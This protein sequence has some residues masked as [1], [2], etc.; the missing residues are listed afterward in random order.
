MQDKWYLDIGNAKDELIKSPRDRAIYRFLEMVPGILS[1]GTLLFVTIMSWLAP[2]F[3]AFFIIAFDIYWLLKTVFLSFHLRATYK[4]MRRYAKI[5][6]L[7]ELKNKFGNNSPQPFLNLREGEKNSPNPPFIKGGKAGGF[8]KEGV[9][10]QEIFHLV[11]LPFYKEPFEVIDETLGAILK[12]NYPKQNLIVVLGAEDRA[13]ENAKK[14]AERIKQKYGNYFFKFIITIHPVIFGEL[15][16]KGSNATWMAKQAKKEIIDFLGLPHENIIVSNLDIDTR[17]YPDYFAR[18]AFE[19]LSAKNPHRCSFQPIPV[20]NNNIWYSNAFSR[21]VATS[22]TF[23]H[24]MQ[25]ERPERLAT[26]S[27]H[28]MSW[29]ALIELDFWNTKNVSEDSR[30]F[31]KSL[32]FYDGAYQVV[33]LYYPVSMDAALAP[34]F[35]ETIIN[36]YRQQKRWGWGSENIP[37][38][39]FGFIKNKKIGWRD[40]IFWT[41]NHLEGFW[42][43]GTNA[44]ILFMLGWLPLFLGGPQFNLTVLSYNLPQVTRVIMTLAMIGLF[45][46]AIISTLLLP[47]RPACYGRHKHLAMV[48]QWALLPI[49]ILIFGSLPGLEAQTRLMLGKYMGFWVTPKG[50]TQKPEGAKG[51]ENR[52]LGG[53]IKT[54]G[55]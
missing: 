7:E 25:Q 31:W 30:I 45:S 6:W 54:E 2:V 13:G 34:T 14:T 49:T 55:F 5:N 42:S 22:G 20:F 16:G 35:L 15:A 33:P 12:A 40:K 38:L 52:S 23:W 48:F 44:I 24:M 50:D 41:F 36:V 11:I 9:N 8:K 51:E 21:V 4:K 46:S 3:I 28:A 1:W 47:P 53:N 29:K 37:Y 17:V 26:F 19:F 10:W 18:L 43:W 39:I 32:L 27:S